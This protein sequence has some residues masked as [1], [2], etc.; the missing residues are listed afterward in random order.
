M[1][2]VAHTV[3][4]DQPDSEIDPIAV[5]KTLEGIL[6]STPFR[7][8]KQC[9][10]MLRYVIEHSLR[11]EQE[12]LRER[13]IGT[14]VFGRSSDYDTSED[15]VVRIRAADIRKRLAQYYQSAAPNS[16]SIRIDIPSG[17]YRA[18]FEFIPQESPAPSVVHEA[19]STPVLPHL[20]HAQASAPVQPVAEPEAKIYRPGYWKRAVWM[21][22]ALLG[23]A[24]PGWFLLRAFLTVP[25][26]DA[27][28][29]FWAPVL[30]NSRP[31]L[32]YAGANAVYH[33]SDS[34]LARYRKEHHI[35]NQGPEFFPEFQPGE[36]IDARDLIQVTSTTSDAQACSDI[37]S[38]LTS[39]RRPYEL[40][41]GSDIAVSDLHD[42]PTIL[43]GAFNNTWTLN[44]TNPLRF[45]F[46]E[47]MRIEDASG[48]TKGW[49]EVK[50]PNGEITDDYA[51][52][53]RLLDLQTG[54]VVITVAGVGGFGTQKAAEILTNPREIME[55]EQNAPAGWQKKNMQIVLH[56]RIQNN[57]MDTANVV[58]A[59]Y[60]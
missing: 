25:S 59:Q 46:K 39:Y 55:L 41:Y 20:A 51:I 15:P 8:S 32:I 43:I 58:A 52:I 12:S 42:S 7:T 40:R 5:R 16:A 18:L 48:K 6:Q 37:V 21:I 13:V 11:N 35:E 34:Y 4:V 30:S 38:L 22:A 10:D 9:Q 27:L 2:H 56:V 23:V 1:A 17:S 44:M 26:Q 54:R 19:D 60:W 45:T 53:S 29:L 47:G 14:E 50:L 33:L 28:S 31:V 49:S 36:K 24:L 3:R 57:V